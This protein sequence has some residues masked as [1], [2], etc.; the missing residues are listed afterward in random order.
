MKDFAIKLAKEAGKILIKDFGRLKSIK[1]KRQNDFVTNAD[2][3]SEK[4]IISKIKEKYPEHSIVSEEKGEE[5]NNSDYTWYIDPLDGTTSFI[6]GLPM[7]GVSIA[8]AKKGD[9]ILGVIYL[10]FFDELYVAEKGKGAYING[11]RT[12]VSENSD[13]KNS[14]I[15]ISSTRVVDDEAHIKKVTRI[16]R[17]FPGSRIIGG[18]SFN[19]CQVA[20]GC[21]DAYVISEP[22]PWDIAAGFLI[23]R[24]AG[25]KATSLDKS[26]FSVET[27]KDI[28]VS[29]GKIHD[30]IVKSLK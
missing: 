2:Y 10:P 19:L 8:L 17:K 4:F 18:A 3:E 30:Q 16:L 14:L 6:H 1:K 20:K 15:N 7:F 29:N 5:I 9:I 22:S 24:E 28:I 27:K 26:G 13:V 23:I 25:G 12:R 21:L 11:K